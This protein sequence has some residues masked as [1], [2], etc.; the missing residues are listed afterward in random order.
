MALSSEVRF[1]S[2]SH[3]HESSWEAFH[4]RVISPLICNLSLSFWDVDLT[5]EWGSA[6]SVAHALVAGTY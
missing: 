4:P 5:N 3:L 2:L 1:L 6:E